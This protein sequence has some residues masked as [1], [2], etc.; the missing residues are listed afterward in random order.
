M[1]FCGTKDVKQYASVL[2]EGADR[3]LGSLRNI[4]N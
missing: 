2:L 3:V 4:T 1:H